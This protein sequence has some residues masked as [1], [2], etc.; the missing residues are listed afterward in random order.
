MNENE[1]NF[2]EDI[3]NIIVNTIINEHQKT[4]PNVLS[5]IWVTWVDKFFVLNGFTTLTNVFDVSSLVNDKLSKMYDDWSPINMVDLIRYGTNSDETYN[6]SHRYNFSKKDELLLNDWEIMSEKS[7]IYFKRPLISEDFYGLSIELKKPKLLSAKIANHVY[8]ANYTN[9]DI[10]VILSEKQ[11]VT[12]VVE[13]QSTVKDKHI[14]NVVDA[15]FSEKYQ[16]EYDKMNLEEFD[17]IN[18]IKDERNYPWKVRD[19]VKDF[20]FI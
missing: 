10:V 3:C 9:D 16:Y 20:M 19:H 5:K 15:C 6:Q 13:G 11:D 18:L 12:I 7:N 1:L 17:F 8:G 4:K 2:N 14:N